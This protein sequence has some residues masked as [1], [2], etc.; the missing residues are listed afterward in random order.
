MG[1]RI[2]MFFDKKIHKMAKFYGL[3]LFIV[4]SLLA[5]LPGMIIAIITSDLVVVEFLLY[6]WMFFGLLGIV[7]TVSLKKNWLRRIVFTESEIRVLSNTSKLLYKIETTKIRKIKRISLGISEPIASKN[8]V[9]HIRLIDAI[10]ICCTEEE[11]EEV[12]R[13]LDYARNRNLIFIENRQGLELLL[14]RF[15]PHIKMEE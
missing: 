10:V 5:I 7:I 12:P 3:I 9:E 6:A 15:L 11:F 2:D 13:F 8:L 14:N 4:N 1:V